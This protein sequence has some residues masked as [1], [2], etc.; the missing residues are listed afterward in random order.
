MEYFFNNYFKKYNKDKVEDKKIIAAEI[1]N[2]IKNFGNAIE[3]N[4][5]IKKLAQKL[6]VPE[7]ILIETLK[8][9]E[10]RFNGSEIAD[11]AKK[12]TISKTRAEILKEKMAG[13]MLNDGIIWKEI[14]IDPVR[15][16]YLL[17]DQE[18]VPILEKGSEAQYKFENLISLVED[19]ESKN[20]LQKIYFDTKYSM[21]EEGVEENDLSDLREQFLYCFNELKKELGKNKLGVLLRDI[22]KAEEGGDNEGKILL[23]NEFNKLSKET[24]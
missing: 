21:A 3:K 24:L 10:N 6:D 20:F 5:W 22:Q 16:N 19:K 17:H 13:I 4:H 2:I 8:K 7:N 9:T 18:F 23:I 1:L 15:R 11:K 12:K 14:S